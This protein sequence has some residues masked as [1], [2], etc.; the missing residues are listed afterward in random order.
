MLKQQ[1]HVHELVSRGRTSVPCRVYVA[2]VIAIDH[3]S[4]SM[5]WREWQLW[6]IYRNVQLEL[7]VE[8]NDTGRQFAISAK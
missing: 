2:G 8:I 3:D 5:N 4:R 1:L 7:L 6:Q